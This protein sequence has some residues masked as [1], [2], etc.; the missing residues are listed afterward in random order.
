MIALQRAG[1]AV[2]GIIDRGQGN[3]SWAATKDLRAAGI[4]LSLIRLG[5]PVRKLHHKLMVIDSQVV[6]A[7]SFNYTDPATRLNDENLLVIGDRD[8]DDPEATAQQS[9]L[10]AHALDEIDRIIATYG[11]PAPT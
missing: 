10:A 8:T 1:I 7:G 3:M 6:I 4:D 5:T 11:E 9:Q 2:R